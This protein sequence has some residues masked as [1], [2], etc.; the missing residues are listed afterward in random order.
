MQIIN[1]NGDWETTTFRN[2]GNAQLWKIE[3]SR[4]QVSKVIYATA[5]HEWFVRDR[6]QTYTTDSLKPG[7]YLQS[8]VM[9]PLSFDLVT[10]AI[11]HGIIYG[12]GTRSIRYKS[13]GTGSHRVHDTNIPMASAYSIN[14]PKFS[15]KHSLVNYF[16]GNPQ[17]SMSDTTINGNPYHHVW[18]K[19]FPVDHNYKLPPLL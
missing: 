15:K 9:K 5:D 19:S 2:Y 6:L 7:M 13:Y 14:I 8:V 18:S 4:D 1:G 16:L 3:L 17:W 11:I 12:D 10:D